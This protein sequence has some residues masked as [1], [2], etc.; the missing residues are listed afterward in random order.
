MAL[1]SAA[2]G[3][4]LPARA[5]P[6]RTHQLACARSIGMRARGPRRGRPSR[7]SSS[8]LVLAGRGASAGLGRRIGLQAR[9]RRRCWSRLG[10]G[11]WRARSLG[12]G[13]ASKQS[14]QPAHQRPAPRS[15]PIAS[16]AQ[17]RPARTR[18]SASLR[19]WP[20]RS[21]AARLMASS[22]VARASPSSASLSRRGSSSGS[23]GRRRE[24]ADEERE[25]DAADAR[26]ARRGPASETDRP[27]VVRRRARSASRGR[28]SASRAASTATAASAR[29][30]ALDL[31]RQ[32]QRRTAA[33]S[34]ATISSD[35]DGT[36]SRPWMRCR[37]QGD[38]LGQVAGPDDQELREARS[39]PTASRRRAAACR[40][41]WKWS[42]LEPAREGLAV[43][44]ASAATTIAKASVARALADD[45]DAPVDGRE[46]VRLERHGP[47]DRGEGHG[48]RVE[49]QARRRASSRSL[50]AEAAV[51]ACGPAAAT[52]RFSTKAEQ[53]SRCAK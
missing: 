9:R 50:R 46:P 39:R 32:Q 38:L 22:V 5:G 15:Q 11:R 26:A 23:S 33:R 29:G 28:R 6:A 21:V 20:G 31:A 36:A 4:R 24:L 35:G 43:A 49:R 17:R 51:A 18:R 45:E 3:A 44:R 8:S 2:C 40:R 19:S 30:V 52:S 48:Q 16:S 10:Q 25:P 7:R 14:K 47:V 13:S 12:A 34:G 27:V 41:S 37:Y 42:R 53:R 1:R